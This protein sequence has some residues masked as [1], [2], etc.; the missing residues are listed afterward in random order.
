MRRGCR[1]QAHTQRA[2]L[3]G[4]GG[5]G[6]VERQPVALPLDETEL[7]RDRAEIVRGRVI[8]GR[9]RRPRLTADRRRRHGGKRY[10]LRGGGGA[11]P[12]QPGL[13]VLG[14]QECGVTRD[15]RHEPTL[16]EPRR[17]AV[18]RRDP[19][20]GGEVGKPQLCPISRTPARATLRGHR[21]G[22]AGLGLRTEGSTAVGRSRAQGGRGEGSRRDACERKFT[23]Q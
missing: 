2:A 1:V 12:A 6:A 10:Q 23:R 16:D 4:G 11:G 5:G 17:A 20:F 19:S 3:R 7:G 14:Q 18:E 9:P 22:E 13:R 15:G 21:L 8:V